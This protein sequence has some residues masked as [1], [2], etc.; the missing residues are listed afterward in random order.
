MRRRGSGQY[1][2]RSPGRCSVPATAATGSWTRASRGRPQPGPAGA[3]DLHVH[4]HAVA[5][6]AVRQ[7]RAGVRRQRPRPQALLDVVPAGLGA[8]YAAAPG[9]GTERDGSAGPRAPGARRPCAR[10]ARAPRLLTRRDSPYMSRSLRLS[11]IVRAR[12]RAGRSG[13]RI[14][15]GAPVRVTQMVS[16]H[17]GLEISAML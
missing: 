14:R 11:L 13:S 15:Y 8:S 1:P 12:I 9:P 10:P 17:R 5:V 7:L 16:G 3:A 2:N 6:R 4:A